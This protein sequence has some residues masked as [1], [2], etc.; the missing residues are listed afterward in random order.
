MIRGLHMATAM[1]TRMGILR[2]TP[3][4]TITERLKLLLT[5]IGTAIKIN[6]HAT[7]MA[8]ATAIRINPLV[9]VMVMV[10]VMATATKTN[11]QKDC[12]QL[13]AIKGSQFMDIVT[14]INLLSSILTE[15]M[16]NSLSRLLK[17]WIMDIVTG[18]VT[19]M[20]I[21]I[22]NK[23]CDTTMAK[24]QCICLFR[25]K[26][27]FMRMTSRIPITRNRIVILMRKGTQ[28]KVLTHITTI[29]Q[30]RLLRKNFKLRKKNR[31]KS[32]FQHSREKTAITS[33]N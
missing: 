10:M 15:S 21:T 32:I 6:L 1:G 9:M 11:I 19:V 17:R 7:F 13:A 4:Y 18:M 16:A 22:R 12:H 24:C 14:L 2:W 25:S 33:K 20:G 3:I 30:S 8:M 5:G 29:L 28:G 23:N 27:Y 26:T 31:K